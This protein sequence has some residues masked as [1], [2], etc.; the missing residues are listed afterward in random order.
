M[1]IKMIDIDPDK[2]IDNQEQRILG[3]VIVIFNNLDNDDDKDQ[4]CIWVLCWV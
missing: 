2:E 3:I 1:V 4:V